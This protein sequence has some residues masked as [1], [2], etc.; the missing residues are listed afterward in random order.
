[1]KKSLVAIL[2]LM[3]CIPALAAS[4]PPARCHV[5][6]LKGLYAFAATGFQRPPDSAPGTP[7]VPKAVVSA[8]QF[9]GDGTLSTPTV[10]L[11]NPPG[12]FGVVISPAGSDG[13]YTINDDCTGTIQYP[14]GV[15]YKMVVDAPRGDTAWMVQTN[16]N[17]V[18]QGKLERIG[19]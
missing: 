12:D 5:G 6:L 16:P 17:T 1:M 8:T 15:M 7:W 10:T 18:F 19:R 4:D 11:A 3:L 14:T 13:V 2:P 9:N